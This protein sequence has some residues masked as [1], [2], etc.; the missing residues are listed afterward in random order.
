M[1][2]RTIPGT[3]LTPTTLCLGTAAIG[4]A[5][6]RNDSAR[7]LDLYLE[8]GGNFID[9]ASVYSD[10]IPGE[11]SRVEKLLGAWM[12]AR[13]NRNRI[14]LATKGGHPRLSSMKTPR[15]ARGEIEA[16]LDA[17]LANLR[18]DT[19]DL[20]WLHRDNQEQPV[21][22]IIDIMNA[23]VRAGKIQYFGC[24]N[25]Q[26]ARIASANLYAERSGQLGFAANQPLWN[27]AYTPP[28]RLA[29]P[30]GVAMDESARQLHIRSQLA[31]IPYTAQ[32]NGYFQRA[33]AGTVG[34]MSESQRRMYGDP[35]NA[36]RAERVDRLAVETGLSISDIVL[37]YL[38][39]QPFP[40]FPI[41]GCRTEAQ[42]RDSM[43]A[44][45]RL[46]TPTQLV[47]LESGRV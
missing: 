44:D 46:L 34:A 41:L 24:S 7:L 43:R 18:A 27:L 14:V 13:G 31:C 33:V 17:S 30:T 12:H 16:D 4:T 25:W 5:I 1:Q 3:S 42:L 10:W 19:I 2:I 45:G 32:A 40:V 26:A 37:G 9:T 8:L 29:D 36:R 21:E 23:Q 11:S 35:E 22:Q 20:Y 15:M 38:L 28:E 39:S 6:S 47:F